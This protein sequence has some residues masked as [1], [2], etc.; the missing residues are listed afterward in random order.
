MLAVRDARGRRI[1][2]VSLDVDSGEIVGVAGLAGSG[3]SEL[4]RII[5]GVQPHDVGSVTLHGG[6]FARPVDS[7]SQRLGIVYIPQE[8]R[9]AGPIPDTAERNLNATTIG[10]HALSAHSCRRLAN[11]ATLLELWSR[12]DGAGRPR[13]TGAEPVRR[14]SAEG[15]AGRSS[16]P[17][18]QPSCCSMIRPTAWMSAPR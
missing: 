6:E 16:S 12:F 14:Q 18:N 4:L 13:R 3:R 8:R 17:S 9:Q 2:G 10:R 5:G 7:A 1:Q 15:D 11:D